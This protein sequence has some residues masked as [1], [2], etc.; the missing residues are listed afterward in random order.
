M[1][2]TRHVQAAAAMHEIWAEMRAPNHA[3][4]LI[5]ESCTWRVLGLVERERSP[6][7]TAGGPR[8]LGWVE[9]FIRENAHRRLTLREIAAV[10]HVHPGHVNKV[11]RRHHRLS[12]G[13]YLRNVQIDRARRRLEA[14]VDPI[15]QV[16]A[17]AGFSD[18]SHFTRVF[19]RHTGV[20]PS[21]YR[22]TAGVAR[23][24][25]R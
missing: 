16:A 24:K 6:A 20:T 12:V 19:K 13:G 25:T 8:W 14:T 5:I 7:T 18:Q 10:A 15:V 1:W 3:S 23:T 2:T 9:E 11:F 4:A 17:E 21:D 22:R